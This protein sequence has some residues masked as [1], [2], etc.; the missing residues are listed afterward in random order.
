MPTAVFESFRHDRK[1]W[2]A[3]FE[4]PLATHEALA[5]ENVIPVLQKAYQA[6]QNGRWAVVLLS[7]EASNAFDSAMAVHPIS[8]FPLAW[9]A[10]FEKPCCSSPKELSSEFEASGWEPRITLAEY[11]GA[12]NKIREFIVKGECYQVN[13]TF[14]MHC[15]FRGDTWGW[16]RQLGEAQKAGYCA[17]IDLGRFRVLSFSPELFFER[18][19]RKLRTR[20]MKGTLSR[21]R[22]LEEDEIQLQRLQSSPKNC[23]E[24]VMIVDLLRNDLGRFS[25][26]GSIEVTSLFEV[27]RYETLFQMTSTI[28]STCQPDMGLIEVMSALFPCGSITGAPKIRSM[29]I[30]RELEPF[31]RQ[32]YTGTV[33]FVRPGGDCIFNVAIRTLL[34]NMEKS[35]ATFGVGGG[36]T[37]DSTAEDEYAECLTKAHFLSESSPPFQLL[38][39]LLLEFGE[40]FLLGRHI[41]RIRESARYFGFTWNKE[42][43]GSQLELTRLSHSEG[44][45][46][47]RLLLAKDGAITTEAFREDS[48]ADKTWRVSFASDPV[49]SQDPFLFNKTTNRSVYERGLRLKRDC[50]DLIF[51]NERGEV[52]ESSVA[53]LVL[54]VDGKKWTPSRSSGLLAGTFRDELLAGGEIAERVIYKEEVKRA[55]GIFL[56]NSVRRWM[57]AVL[58]D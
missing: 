37:Y 28:E 26:P 9:V 34:L 47:I 58:V 18:R 41:E 27:E 33:G 29:E 25:I 49:N 32:I 36:I 12:I 30:I 57:P 48:S 3:C 56:I 1:G 52:T 19:G 16:Y 6:A 42:E 54:V 5:S 40:Y 2:S 24:N 4:K 21:G 45:F 35:E 17:W 7:Y 53:N 55:T 51:W 22:W 31:A 38:E 20:P 43:I 39:T 46:R 44:R 8:E 15:R 23:A 50:D 13:Y 10:E 14:P 11:K